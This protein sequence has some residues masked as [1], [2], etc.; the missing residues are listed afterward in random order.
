[1]LGDVDALDFLD[2]HGAFAVVAEITANHAF[3]LQGLGDGGGACGGFVKALMIALTSGSDAPV[4]EARYL[5]AVLAAGGLPR[6]GVEGKVRR[7]SFQ[8]GK[9]LRL[10][11][12]P[13]TFE[14][15]ARRRHAALAVAG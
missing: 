15:V 11:G 4:P 2:V 3:N 8:D 10:G 6:V 1:M 5:D 13:E 12:G 9:A 7:L 14:V